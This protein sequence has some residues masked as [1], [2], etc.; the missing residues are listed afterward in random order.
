M[1]LDIFFLSRNIGIANQQKCKKKK[2]KVHYGEHHCCL[3]CVTIH[4][5]K[6][7]ARA[8]AELCSQGWAYV[9]GHQGFKLQFSK[10]NPI[11]SVRDLK[12][13]REEKLKI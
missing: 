7:H 4:P 10:I 6:A 5:L 12:G 1:I 8:L 11:Q 9:A 3:P 13:H 2:C